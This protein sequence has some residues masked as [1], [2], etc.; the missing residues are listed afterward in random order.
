M[1]IWQ[2]ALVRRDL[3]G[4][5]E[6]APCFRDLG[7]RYLRLATRVSRDHIPHDLRHEKMGDKLETQFVANEQNTK[8]PAAMTSS[9]VV[10][11]DLVRIRESVRIALTIAA[12]NNRDVLACNIR[13][14]LCKDC[15]KRIWTRA[16][17]EF[18]SEAG[19]RILVVMSR[20]SQLL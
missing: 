1:E 11:R 19:Q 10:S 4:N 14:V 13:N 17:T 20:E 15:L 8:T 2:H 7:E 12:L 5:E 9:S 16:G 18:G 3:Q 6:R